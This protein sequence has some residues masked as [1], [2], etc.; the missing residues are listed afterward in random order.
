MGIRTILGPRGTEVASYL[1]WGACTTAVNVASFVALRSL[2]RVPV[3]PANAAAWALAV[4]FAFA[5]NRAFVFRPETSG[6]RAVAGELAKFTAARLA[7]GAADMALVY[8]LIDRAR[9]PETATKVAIN[10][11]VVAMNY[12]AGKFFVFAKEKAS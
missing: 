5:T 6:A 9:F 2:A 1:F 8:A 7:S 11:L 12:V 4:L 10:V 3:V